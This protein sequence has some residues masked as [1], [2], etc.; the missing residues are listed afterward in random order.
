MIYYST[1]ILMYPAGR[2]AC[3]RVRVRVRGAGTT[4]GHGRGHGWTEG[5]TEG[6]KEGRT[7]GRKGRE[8]EVT[9][10]WNSPSL[11]CLYSV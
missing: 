3:V 5:R 7:E 8:E 2:R 9:S 1:Y 10:G 6:R 11:H 4:T